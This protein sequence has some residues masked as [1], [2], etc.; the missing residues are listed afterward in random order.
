MGLLRFFNF[1]KITT[2][3]KIRV[4]IQ[5]KYSVNL[6]YSRGKIQAW[7]WNVDRWIYINDKKRY[8][9]ATSVQ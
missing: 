5:G 9:G 1:K 6:D 3:S 7:F 4:L 8:H 2:F